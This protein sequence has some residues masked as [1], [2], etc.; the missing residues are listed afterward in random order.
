MTI[1]EIIFN[2]LGHSFPLKWRGHYSGSD[3]MFQIIFI[4]QQQKSLQEIFSSMKLAKYRAKINFSLSFLII[5]WWVT[6][7]VISECDKITSYYDRTRQITVLTM[8]EWDRIMYYRW[9]NR[10]K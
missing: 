7:I 2:A 10:T 8:K 3:G 4:W 1:S 9:K 6:Q 5:V